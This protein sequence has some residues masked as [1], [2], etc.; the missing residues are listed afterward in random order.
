MTLVAENQVRAEPSRPDARR[1]VLLTSAAL[2]AISAAIHV[3]VMSAHVREWL[4]AAVFFG[5]LAMGQ[6]SLAVVLVRRPAPITLLA[7]I[8]SSVGVIA[9]YV[10]S[11]TS[12]LPFAPVNHGDAHGSGGSH[13]AHAV[14][15]HGN[16]VPIFPGQ[17][18]ATSAEPLGPL[19]LTSVVAELAV[20]AL[21]IY[22][23]P[24]R[25]RRWTGNGIFV[26]GLA[27]LA[28]RATSVLN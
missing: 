24:P 18:I 26:C 14:G 12:G 15:G 6:A 27:M 13:L 8:W 19:D 1:V 4:P 9:V 16:G 5:V 21:L 22:L 10:W 20:V 23:L 2:L 11:R 28:L 25:H 3:D 17:P 7:A